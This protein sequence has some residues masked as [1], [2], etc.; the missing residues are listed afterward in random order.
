MLCLQD[1]TLSALEDL[2]L[3]FTEETKPLFLLLLRLWDLSWN[4]C[5]WSPRLLALGIAPEVQHQLFDQF[6]ECS[7]RDPQSLP[8]EH[9][10]VSFRSCF[11]AEIR[12][13][14]LCKYYYLKEDY[15]FPFVSYV[16]VCL[17]WGAKVKRPRFNY[18]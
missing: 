6:A 5:H 17:A 13:T 16:T 9:M 3:P 2:V 12:R 7:S 1:E 18:L 8:H 14:Q 15:A 11:C 4:C 10:P